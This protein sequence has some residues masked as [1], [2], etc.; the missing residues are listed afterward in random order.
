MQGSGVTLRFVG[1]DCVEEGM[2]SEI[3]MEVLEAVLVTCKP[4]LVGAAAQA[5]K[6]FGVKLRMYEF[7]CLSVEVAAVVGETE[8]RCGVGVRHVVNVCQG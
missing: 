5:G 3:G 6:V 1:E 7:R 8:M 4:S 2:L